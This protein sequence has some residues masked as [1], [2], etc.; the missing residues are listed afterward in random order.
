[1]KNSFIL[2]LAGLLIFTGC[3]SHIY[4][5]QFPDN[6]EVVTIPSTEGSYYFEVTAGPETKTS[7]ETRLLNSE[8]R[9]IIDKAII[10]QQMVDIFLADEHINE[11]D[12]FKVDFNV[13]AN[14]SLEQRNVVVEV[15]KAMDSRRYKY[16]VDANDND[17]QVVWKAI[18]LG[19]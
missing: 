2:A 7:F 11:G 16:H 15:L 19:R 1:M 3:L 5:V 9:V 14:E 12:V 4:D 18:Q 13:P 17:W 8:Y 10:N 6:S